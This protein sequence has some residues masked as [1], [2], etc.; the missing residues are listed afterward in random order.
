MDF[1]KALKKLGYIKRELDRD[2]IFDTSLIEKVHPGKD[3]Y[4]DGIASSGA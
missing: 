1:V 3:H 4:G 2:E